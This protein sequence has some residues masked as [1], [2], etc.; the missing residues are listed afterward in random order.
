MPMN[1]LPSSPLMAASDKSFWHAYVDFYARQFPADID[2][3]V[4]EFGVLN[5]NSIRWLGERFPS[6]ELV[7]VDILAV[8]PTWPQSPAHPLCAGWTRTA[9][10]RWPRSSPALPRRSSSSRPARTSPRHQ[11]R[12][13]RLGLDRLAAGGL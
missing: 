6:A 1:N 8:Q 4:V 2:G 5:G 11:S 12:C 7:G 10:P 3:L 13:L 9:R